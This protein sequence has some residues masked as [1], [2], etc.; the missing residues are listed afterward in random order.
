VASLVPALYLDPSRFLRLETWLLPSVQ[1][2]LAV[3][4]A[5]GW[6]LGRILYAGVRQDRVFARLSAHVERIE[7]LDLAPLR[8][9]ARRGLRR[10]A[11]WLLLASLSIPI[12]ADAGLAAWPALWLAA[13][14]GF[15]GFSF[16]LPIRG[17]V[18]RIRQEKDTELARVRADIRAE[19]D[20]LRGEGGER[21]GGVL[22][23]LIA[24]EDRIAEARVWP[25]DTGI[26]TRLGVFLLL[27]L[28]SW[29]GG[30]FVERA[31][32]LWLP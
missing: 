20:R 12:F 24:Y 14:L 2:D 28:G 5:F 8:P 15:A 3:G 27:P 31:V 21:Q 25:V 9:F 1:F 17:I 30:A 4:A 6:A 7:L 26:L 19:R 29:L 18:R 22:A 11:R 16:V 23:D 10:S 32:D 13:I